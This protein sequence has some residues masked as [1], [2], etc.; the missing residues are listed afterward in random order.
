MSCSPPPR[1]PG[2][3]SSFH[4]QVVHLHLTKRLSEHRVEGLSVI[5]RPKEPH[6]Q[7]SRPPEDL[8]PALGVEI[9]HLLRRAARSKAQPNDPTRRGADDEIDDFN[10]RRPK[11]ALKLREVRRR[12]DAAH[13]AAV[14][15]KDAEGGAYVSP[16]AS[17]QSRF[18]SSIVDAFIA[19]T[20]YR[21]SGTSVV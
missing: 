18:A 9:E 12:E 20:T 2:A 3:W 15:G 11:R 19:L 6:G 13:P 4:T 10:Q 5:P 8:R 1:R 16:N 14:K 21:R 17:F 7:P